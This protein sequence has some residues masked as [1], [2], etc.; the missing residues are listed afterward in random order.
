VH[1]VVPA[2]TSRHHCSTS[3]KS[4]LRWWNHHSIAFHRRIFCTRVYKISTMQS[5][6][7][8]WLMSL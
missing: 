5:Y 6:S 3:A 4:C 1:A 8:G 7:G 2:R